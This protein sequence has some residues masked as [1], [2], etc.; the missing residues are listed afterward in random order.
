MEWWVAELA[1][2]VESASLEYQKSAEIQTG[3]EQLREDSLELDEARE[4]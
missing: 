2:A 3:C 4:L 1:H